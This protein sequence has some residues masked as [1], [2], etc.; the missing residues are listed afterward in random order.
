MAAPIV[1]FDIAGKA[2]LCLFDDPAGNYIG[3]LELQDGEIKVP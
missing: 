2:V 3:L 1:F